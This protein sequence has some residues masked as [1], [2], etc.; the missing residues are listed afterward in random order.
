MKLYK[1][2]IIFGLSSILLY[3]CNYQL[4][5][6]HKTSLPF[7]TLS[8]TGFIGKVSDTSAISKVELKNFFTDST[9]LNYINQGLEKNIDILIASQNI[10]QAKAYI[11]KASGDLLPQL[12]FSPNSSLTK[13]GYYTPDGLGNYYNNSSTGI[14]KNEILPTHLP[15]YFLGISTSWELDIWKKLKLKKNA[16]LE[17]AL[18]SIETQKWIKTNITANIAATYYELISLDEELKIIDQTIKLQN[19][20]LEIVQ[21]QKDAGVVNEFIVNQF[22]GQVLNSE[23][24][25]NGIIQNIKIAENELNYLLGKFPQDVVRENNTFNQNKTLSV[26]T[27]IPSSFLL[28]R[29]D[30]KASIHEVKAAHSLLKSS[31]KAL[32]PSFTIG[33]NTGFESFNLST[34]L[35]S[36][37]SF[38]YNILGGISSPLLNK[39]NIKADII[40]NQSN[41]IKEI[42]SYHQTLHKAYLEV[43]NNLIIIDNLEK[44]LLLKKQESDVLNNSVS[45]VN[46]LFTTGKASYIEVLLANEKAIEANLELVELKRNKLIQEVYLFKALGGV[47]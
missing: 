35:T 28:N 21:I 14:K 15:N 46:E 41:K 39:K 13:F 10:E 27:S 44:M 34:F 47:N 42:Y 31:E 36:P 5:S 43:Y 1:L 12:S 19:K 4:V 20:A 23:N 6:S 22:Q 9:L 29:P 37:A 18:A 3:S 40:L 17:K 2:I 25:R 11:Q 38:A 30:V 8:S 24:H 16:A 45:I 33:L 7:D 26:Y 32:L